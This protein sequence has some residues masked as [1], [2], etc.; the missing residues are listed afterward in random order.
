MLQAAGRR[1]LSSC[2]CSP[3][4]G[5][6]TMQV[7]PGT[8][9]RVLLVDDEP[10]VLIALEDL[11]SDDFEILKT[12]SPHGALVIRQRNSDRSSHESLQQKQTTLLNSILK[13]LA[14]GVVVTDQ[15][16]NFL[17]CNP[18][19]E[20]V[21]GLNPNALNVANWVHLCGLYEA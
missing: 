20:R 10:Q 14:E 3:Q 5:A 4:G 7:E 2:R 19:A 13:G 18:E 17:L 9:Q 11:L 21:L 1:R 15:Q 6:K 16:G 8:K 12:T